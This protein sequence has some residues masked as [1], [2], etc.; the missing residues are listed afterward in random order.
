MPRSSAGTSFHGALGGLLAGAVVAAWFFAVDAAAGR[1]FSTPALLAA[2]VLGSPAAV[3]SFGTV[4]A[5]TLVHFGGFALLGV[6]AARALGR[7]GLAPTLLLGVL[8]GVGVLDSVYYGTLLLTDA[9]LLAVLPARHVLLANLAG[10]MAFTSYLHRVRDREAPFGLGT[11]RG[12]PQVRRGIVT[13]LFGAAAVALWF[14][15]LDVLV[16][17]PFRTPAALGS[18]LFL[19]AS[20]PDQTVLSAGMVAAYTAVHIAAFAGF[21]TA[22]VW[23]AERLEQAPDLWLL[24]LLAFIVLDALVLGTLA[25]LSDWVLGALGWVTV[26]GGNLAALGAMGWWIW[27]THPGIRDHLAGEPIGTRV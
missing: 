3:V 2:T 18:M 25:L 1:P 8:F 12:F 19:G 20:T 13:G 7:L 16:G 6:V 22:L 9:N 27:R 10:G 17:L 5:Y 14:F 15:V 26:A 4:A 24:G 23:A 11:L 21:G